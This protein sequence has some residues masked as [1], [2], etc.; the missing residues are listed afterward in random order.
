[1]VQQRGR[2]GDKPEPQLQTLGPPNPGAPKP[3][4]GTTPQAHPKH[5]FPQLHSKAGRVKLRDARVRGDGLAGMWAVGLRDVGLSLAVGVG[6]VGTRTAVS[7]AGAGPAVGDV[8]P[9]VA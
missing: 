6:Q 2:D 9:R 5:F 8:V 3:R 4:G 1:M 7:V